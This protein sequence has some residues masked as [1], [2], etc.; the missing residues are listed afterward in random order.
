MTAPAG[1]GPDTTAPA[2]AD[3]T[4]GTSS[5]ASSGSS[6]S[7]AVSPGARDVWLRSRGLLLAAV[8]VVL[9]GFVIALLRSG[10]N[11]WLHPDAA[12]PLGSRAVTELL[13]DR[14]VETTL[15][16]GVE[17]AAASAGPDTTLLVALPEALTPG[18]RE[19]LYEATADSG[20]RTVLVT[21]GQ[22][23]LDV[24]APA[25]RLESPVEPEVREP[26][27]EAEDAR[28]AGSAEL[29]GFRYQLPDT[30]TACYPAGG[31]PTL[32]TLPAGDGDTVLLGSPTLLH[33]ENLADHG[34]ASLALQLLGTRSQLSWYLP[35]LEDMPAPEDEQSFVELLDP[36]WKWGALQLVIATVLAALWRARR[37]G[38]VVTERL[39]VTVRAAETTEGRARLY[40]R[41]GARDRAAE[42][43]RTASRDRL[44][45][46]VGL[47]Q[48]AH[49]PEVLPA[50]VAA[51]TGGST[52]DVRALLFGPPPADDT[53]LVG[54]ADRL[55]ALEL[56]LRPAGPPPTAS[57]A[58]TGLRNLPDSPDSG[59][60]PLR[61]KDSS[62]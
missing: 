24:F 7:S 55:D 59:P 20:G 6:D 14:G 60:F 50:A 54:L 9:A 39:P 16:T 28:R 2:G 57:P 49:D 37:L 4:A 25:A 46:L 48:A 52:T 47:A 32:V 33:N 1:T 38:P 21:P 12:T 58:E 11:G 42:A 41:A 34:N 40:H 8:A 36:G 23:T 27:C 44:A 31:L 62:S 51:R 5:G 3:S 35:S 43:L 61:D 19:A 18:Q 22:A 30:G 45:S 53:A 29:G 10:E 56:H 15:A 13:A 17:E 26:G